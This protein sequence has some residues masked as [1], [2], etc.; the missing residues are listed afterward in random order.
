MQEEKKETEDLENLPDFENDDEADLDDLVT[1][2]EAAE[3]LKLKRTTLDH[4]R[5]R[6]VDRST[7]S[8]AEGCFTSA[9]A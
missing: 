6:D 4:Y 5:C 3:I 2:A 9:G 7:E 1:V 8:M